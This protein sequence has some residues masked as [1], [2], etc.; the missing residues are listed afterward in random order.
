MSLGL[1]R[2]NR[3]GYLFCSLILWCSVYLSDFNEKIL[4]NSHVIN[5]KEAGPCFM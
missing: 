5:F 1:D 2:P 3:F 4:G